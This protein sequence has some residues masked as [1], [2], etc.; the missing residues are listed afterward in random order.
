[1]E[2]KLIDYLNLAKE[3]SGTTLIALIKKL[4]ND[5]D[6]FVFGEFIDLPSVRDFSNPQNS[7]GSKTFSLLELFAFGNWITYSNNKEKYGELTNI[8]QKKL[9]Q[10]T[11]VTLASKNKQI[12]YNL[13]MQELEINSVREMED[14]VL[15]TFYQE[16]VGGKL[17]QS[18]KLIHIDKIKGRDIRL[19]D[20]HS[21]NEKLHIWL[22]KS[23]DLEKVIQ[24]S[25][26][27]SQNEI[28]QYAL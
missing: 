24:T 1:M 19:N 5:P 22:K 8:Q 21:M 13:L 23:E 3:Y 6:I 7:D 12:P 4:L 26:Q 16:L 11:I 15:D 28:K 9:K 2:E 25:I 20:L 14:L 10:L 18:N 27:H 17:D